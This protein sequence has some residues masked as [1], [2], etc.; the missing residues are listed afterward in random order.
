MDRIKR[1]FKTKPT[2]RPR[3]LSD[4]E[5]KERKKLREQKHRQ[6]GRNKIISARYYQRH[7]N[8]DT[9]KTKQKIYND[10]WITSLSP[11]EK[12]QLLA[13]QKEGRQRRDM[14][15]PRRAMLN[16]SRKRAKERGL[17]F[18]ITIDDIIIPTHCPV[19][20]IPLV[21][22]GGKRTPNSPSVDRVNNSLGY[23]KGNI[24]VISSRANALK[25]DGTIDEFEKII[26]YMEQ[27]GLVR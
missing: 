17:E 25:N 27:H 13:L 14:K 10:N 7:K 20:G 2:G 8:T 15:E 19:L 26:Q 24:K 4:E 16:N 1:Q 5:R 6:S 3:V 23:V 21:K 22:I 9:F 11:E 12:D 18:T